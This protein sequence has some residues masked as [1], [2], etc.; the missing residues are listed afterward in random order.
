[1]SDEDFT[2]KGPPYRF[3]SPTGGD[4]HPY[5]TPFWAA[6]SIQDA[7]DASDPGDSIMVAEGT[8][9]ET[10]T[11]TASLHIMGG[12][13]S[14]FTVRDPEIYESRIQR[15]G[16]CVSF[17]YLGTDYCGIEGMTIANGSG[18]SLS[19][20]VLGNYG[21]GIFAYN[22]SPLIKENTFVNCGTASV[23]NFSGGG[24]ISVYGG[25]AVI[26]SNEITACKGQAGGGIYLYMATAD[27]IGNR[28]TDCYGNF[29]YN[30]TRG[31]GGVY[32]YHGGF[33][34][35]NNVISG[36]YDYKCG[37]AVYARFSPASL[38]GD[39][40]YS[41]SVESSG[42]A[43]SAER[44]TMIFSGVVITGNTSGTFG[45]GIYGKS[46]YFEIENTIVA[47]NSS[48]FGGG[49]FPDS[50]TGVMTNNTFDRN[51][52]A[53]SGGGIY[54]GGPGAL[55]MRNNI[56]SYSSPYG[57]VA[58]D[59]TTNTYLYNNCYGN[60]PDDYSGPAPDT[61]NIYRNPHYADTTAFDYHLLVHSGSIDTGDPDIAYNDPDGSRADQGAFGGS[62][63]VMAA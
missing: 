49:I 30:G 7:V 60:S 21:G 51:T 10:V 38:S 61:T 45:G 63:A 13:D 58:I 40:L 50:C 48:L 12:W 1:W 2:I 62:A 42:G 44:D 54:L 35:E 27:I 22:S 8:Y 4:I 14:G 53:F 46:A 23:L 36:C 34:M 55:D 16:S 5:S 20:P 11:A 52:A 18:T 56:F 37:G 32:A 26:E 59:L 15:S 3:V 6:H 57:V 31:G 25:H 41:N 43:V 17:M 39:S 33:T 29:E 28:I 24:A 47:K 9:G 19:M